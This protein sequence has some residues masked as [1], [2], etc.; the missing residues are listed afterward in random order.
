L[1]QAAR[2]SLYE[3]TA[4]LW[5]T[6]AAGAEPTLEQRAR[7]RLASNVAAA[8]AV[9]AVD[10]MYQAGGGAAIYASSPL[11]RLLGHAGAAGRRY[12]VSRPSRPSA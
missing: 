2:S 8:N 5:E 7:V 10:T 4:A 12:G 1:I 9:Q 6:V 11:D 3:A